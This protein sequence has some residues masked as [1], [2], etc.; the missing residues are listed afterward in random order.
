M[1]KFRKRNKISEN[2]TNKII[3]IHIPNSKLIEHVS[4][5]RVLFDIV[6]VVVR[7]EEALAT[8]VPAFFVRPINVVRGSCTCFVVQK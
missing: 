3:S 8:S 4:S 1:L 2:A 6:Y 7:F 5:K